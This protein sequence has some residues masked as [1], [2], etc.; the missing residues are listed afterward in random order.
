M[1]GL[2]M[3]NA[4]DREMS[5]AWC[6]DG[7][8]CDSRVWWGKWLMAIRVAAGDGVSGGHCDHDAAILGATV[9]SLSS[10]LLFRSNACCLQSSRLLHSWCSGRRCC[11]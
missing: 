3:R 9:R 10:L 6:C 2:V 5:Y 1:R 11:D 7:R 8:G 4:T